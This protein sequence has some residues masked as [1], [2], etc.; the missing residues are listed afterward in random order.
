M[1]RKKQPPKPCA[2]QNCGKPHWARGFCV[3]HYTRAWKTGAIRRVPVKVVNANGCQVHGC[4]KPAY[5]RG[6]CQAHYEKFK[7][8]GDPLASAVRKTGQPCST[9]GCSGLTVARGLCRNCYGHFRR[10]GSAT[11]RSE[12]F[13]KRFKEIV[14]D[15]GYVLVYAK[16]HPNAT[17]S[18]RVH[19]HRLAMSEFLG[20]PLR[21]G[22]NVH[23]KNGDKLDNR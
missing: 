19:K 17:R 7:K 10:H 16:G 21:D 11:T 18:G 22:E 14:D 13:H 23:H 15:H 3:A 1:P 4:G 8:Y 6:Y 20:R 9:R 12:W 5:G 2:V